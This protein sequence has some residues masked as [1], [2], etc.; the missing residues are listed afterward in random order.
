M[1]SHIYVP[2]FDNSSLALQDRVSQPV[3]GKLLAIAPSGLEEK[4]D[5]VKYLTNFIE[6]SHLS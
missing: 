4:N 5:Y 6:L 3:C 2:V 1:K